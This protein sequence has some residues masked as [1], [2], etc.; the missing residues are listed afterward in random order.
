M[1]VNIF[2]SDY[3]KSQVL[4]L[5]I[6]PVELPSLSR[7]S[8]NE[9]FE[10]WW[11]GTYNFIEKEGLLTFSI[12]SWFPTNASKY[13]FCKSQVNAMQIINLIK[14]TQEKAEPLRITISCDNGEVYVNDTFSIDSFSYNLLRRGDYKYL[15]NVKQWRQYT[16]AVTNKV[17]TIGWAQDSTGWWYYTSTTGDYYKNIWQ[18]IENEWYS[19]KSDGYARQSEWYQDGVSWYYLKDS[20]KM[21]RNEWVTINEK[22]YYFGE[23][24]AMYSNCYTPDGYW[25]NSDGVW[26]S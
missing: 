12:E 2:I 4:Q 18:L 13:S 23:S 21:A 24:G 11:D 9:E 7:T 26:V 17:Y 14:I 15:L 8:S 20:C 1:N 3:N 19:F 6:V 10:T 25:V 5:P 22:S 16:N